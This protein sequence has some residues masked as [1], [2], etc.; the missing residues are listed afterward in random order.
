MNENRL[1]T[2][3]K[4]VDELM[5]WKLERSQQQ[6]A[7]PLDKASQ[8][9]LGR[10]FLRIIQTFNQVGGVAGRVFRYFFVQQDLL[11]GSIPE[12]RS[13]RFTVNVTSNVLTV[14][15][16]S[17]ADT[18][19]VY[20]F[21]SDTLP[22][23]LVNGTTYYIRDSTGTTFKLALTSGGTAIDITTAGTGIHYINWF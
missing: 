20:V 12:D 13:V 7:Y 5:A 11:I 9:V 15:G 4:K 8:D 2:L 18:D 16:H 17:F 3:E 10:Y 19:T 1:Q 22:S 21:T 6:I 14:T 23:P